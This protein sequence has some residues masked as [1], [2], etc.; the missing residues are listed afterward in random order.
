[1]RIVVDTNVLVSA[2]TLPGAR[3]DEALRKIAEGDDS[4]ALSGP[5]LDELLV[6]DNS[7]FS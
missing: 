3:G 1:M 4:L 6:L 2:L 7:C 5:I